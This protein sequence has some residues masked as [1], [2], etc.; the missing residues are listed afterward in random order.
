MS[1]TS[2]NRIVLLLK[3]LIEYFSTTSI[4]STLN[5][6]K[7]DESMEQ[8]GFSLFSIMQLKKFQVLKASLEEVRSALDSFQTLFALK[9]DC[10][11]VK[12][13]FSL[14]EGIKQLIEELILNNLVLEVDGFQSTTQ[15]Q[16]IAFFSRWGRVQSCESINS[17]G[18]YWIKFEKVQSLIQILLI[19]SLTFEDLNIMTKAVCRDPHMA[20][21]DCIQEIS[22]KD[23]VL[24]FI[25]SEDDD[26]VT[27]NKLKQVISSLSQVDRIEYNTGSSTGLVCFKSQ[28]AASCLKS[29]HHIGPLKLGEVILELSACHSL[30]EIVYDQV[31]TIKKIAE[32]KRMVLP[33]KENRKKSQAVK[34][35]GQGGVGKKRSK[36]MITKSKATD[37]K[38]VDDLIGMFTF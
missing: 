25:L 4:K 18:T 23:R 2:N 8:D 26:L 35:K 31:W 16:I 30:V 33:V 27:A 12:S 1:L 5:T 11:F 29:A 37:S 15:G 28:V 38:A 22:K 19:D 20:P 10:F 17:T 9:G 21:I 32:P 13:E 24:Q 7:S 36:A 34:P 3:T 14:D 6:L